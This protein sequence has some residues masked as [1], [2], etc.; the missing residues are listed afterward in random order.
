MKE[1]IQDNSSVDKKSLKRHLLRIACVVVVLGGLI[2]IWEDVIEDRVIPKR[3]GVIEEGKIYR[4]GRLSSALVKRV[5]EKHNI[6]VIVSLSGEKPN[7]K[8]QNAERKAAAELGIEI[9]RFPLSG[10]GTGDIKN[11]A[12]AIAAMVNARR[13][14]KPVLIHCAAGTQRTGAVTACYRMLVENR[15]PEFAYKE[16]L[17]YDYD[18]D[19]NPVLLS[20][21]NDNMADLVSLLKEM[22]V[23]DEVPAP[24][25]LL[26]QTPQ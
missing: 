1:K 23:I 4:S 17:R 8:D 24:L 7:D 3:W 9:L 25:P 22:E 19:K 20:Y 15:S 6:V 11:Y 16:L 26:P 18:P 21:V 10:N 12:Q 2:W 14:N 5:L 13:M